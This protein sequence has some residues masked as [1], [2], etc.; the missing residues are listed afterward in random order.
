M[1]ASTGARYVPVPSRRC[2]CPRSEAFVVAARDRVPVVVA[3][4]YDVQERE[5]DPPAVPVARLPRIPE[6]PRRAPADAE[7]AAAAQVL[8]DAR[9]PIV[10]AGR[11]AVDSG[12]R[13]ARAG[14]T[15]RRPAR[16]DAVRPR[17]VPGEPF[18]IGLVGGLS[19]RTT[20]ELVAEAD[21]VLAVGAG[22]GYF[23]TDN[24]ALLRGKTVIQVDVEPPGVSEGVRVATSFVR[25]DA[26]LALTAIDTEL[27]AGHTATGF[28]TDEIATRIAQPAGR[29]PG[30]RAGA[31]HRRPGGGDRRAR[32]RASRDR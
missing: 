18:D 7:I 28:R 15:G 20:R 2:S 17:L 16:D 29:V 24:G 4:P 21:V 1:T 31:G 10:L 32:R 9:R 3:V 19:S 13:D 8:A 11:G 25:G 6:P 27:G 5:V 22:L 23:A 26:A 12:A 14:R 30:G